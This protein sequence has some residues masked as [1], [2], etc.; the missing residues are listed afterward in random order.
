MHDAVCVEF[1]VLSCGAGGVR[2][3]PGAVH[4][5][6]RFVGGGDF[7]SAGLVACAS[8]FEGGMLVAAGL[9]AGV[10][11]GGVAFHRQSR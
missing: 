11:A 4:G 10:V 2:D 5:G 9:V 1:C 7:V 3:G 8:A 6:A